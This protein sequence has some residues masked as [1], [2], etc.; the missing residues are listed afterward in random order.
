MPVDKA[1][2]FSHLSS[3]SATTVARPPRAQRKRQPS[4]PSEPQPATWE[5]TEVPQPSASSASPPA[6]RK[7]GAVA[8]EAKKPA[9]GT[10]RQRKGSVS[11]D[12]VL[13]GETILNKLSE[14]LAADTARAIAAAVGDVDQVKV[15]DKHFSLDAQAPS[16]KIRAMPPSPKA[17]PNDSRSEV[18]L[19]KV[20]A[21]SPQIRLWLHRR[22]EA[23]ETANQRRDMRL[24]RRGELSMLVPGHRGY[25][26]ADELWDHTA[27]SA[28][29][30]LASIPT[31]SRAD[32]ISS[33]R[34]RCTARIYGR[35]V[36][37]E[38]F[39]GPISEMTL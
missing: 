7:E 2:C 25:V 8:A 28:T 17:T 23:V 34:L 6:G 38:V 24:F 33:A 1:A 37:N 18:R 5:K 29:T 30:A 3:E 32:N 20:S 9:D 12:V 11:A 15:A 14:A 4:A 21:H 35:P 13:D 10:S 22:T 26:C 36:W 39:G 31:R 27:P 19:S 16:K